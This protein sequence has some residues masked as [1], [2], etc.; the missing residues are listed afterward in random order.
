MHPSPS[1]SPF[2]SFGFGLLS[3]CTAFV[4][5]RAQ[6]AAVRFLLGVF[7]AG[8]SDVQC[9]GR[10]CATPFSLNLTQVQS[11]GCCPV[12]LTICPDGTERQNSR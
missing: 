8:K 3:L 2:I 1:H 12:S 5:N 6:A 7:E 10:S 4:H 9:N 11:Q